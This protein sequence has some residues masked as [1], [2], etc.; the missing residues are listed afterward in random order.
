MLNLLRWTFGLLALLA[1]LQPS[2][3]ASDPPAR[4]GRLSLA[5]GGVLFR[6]D[7]QDTGSAA[8]ANWPVSSGAI[9]DTERDGRA[10]AWIGSTAFRLGGNSRLEFAVVDDRQV[11]LQLAAGVLAVT[12]RDRDQ[13]DGVDIVTPQGR[14][15]FFEP[16]RYRIEVLGDRTTV[17]AQS[18]MAEAASAGQVLPVRSG[19]MA[20]MFDGGRLDMA[21]APYGDDFDGWI[22][23]QDNR[24]RSRAARQHVSPNMTGYQ[25]LDVYGDWDTVADYGAV[26]Y[27]RTVVAG[28]APYRYGRWAWIAPWGWT[29][30]DAAP[31]GFAPFHYGRWVHTRGRWGWAPGA[32]AA[33]PVYAPALVGW[34]GNPGWSVAFSAG[35]APAVGWFP[36]APRE[37][38]V[39][40]YRTSPTY[41]RQINVTHV[42]NVVDIDRAAHPDFRPRYAHHGQPQAVT[43]VP[44][45]LLREGRPIDRAAFRPTDRH[46]L[47]QAPAATRAP[48]REWLTPTSEAMRPAPRSEGPR[49]APG[50][51]S[52]PPDRLPRAAG[53]PP[54][55]GSEPR[56]DMAPGLPRPSEVGQRR[57]APS[58]PQETMRVMPESVRNA[59]GPG[60]VP[61]SPAE[62]PRAE[63]DNRPLAPP[64]LSPAAREGWQRPLPPVREIQQPAPANRE[65]PRERPTPMIREIP[66]PSPMPREIRPDVQREPPLVERAPRDTWQRPPPPVREIQQPVPANREAPRERP[67][68][69]IREI[70]PPTPMPREIRPD[71]QREPPL[72]ERAPRERPA[73]VVR[74]APRAAPPPPVP[75]RETPRPEQR[76]PARDVQGGNKGH[77]DRRG[78]RDQ[79]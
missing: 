65:V 18:G 50:Q 25:D 19:E 47:G 53:N 55:V 4:V 12:V 76:P 75:M 70:Q 43:V 14:V 56:R 17:A 77:N 44:A 40:A 45:N 30:I 79:R 60:R 13:A 21:A 28:W 36:L 54:P 23:A 3:A 71:V 48:G 31:W 74:E 34:V 38:Y 72:V 33:R 64:A 26:W 46:E 62:I 2:L 67:T 6:T 22:T 51:P 52:P 57:P 59:E 58:N 32:Y 63:H 37:V 49:V 39:P 7:R 78:D 27:P 15:R 5:E 29:W 42:T 68:P 24:E 41:I 9:L 61:A 73:P 35:S 8:M 16:G 20:T 1:Y 66:P 11:R 69:M 10:E